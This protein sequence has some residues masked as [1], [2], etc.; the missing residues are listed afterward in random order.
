MILEHAIS[1]TVPGRRYLIL[2]Q[3]GFAILVSLP[4]EPETKRDRY[5]TSISM[6]PEWVDKRSPA[7]WIQLVFCASQVP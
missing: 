6:V 3:A 5:R 1:A 2:K 7:G 4:R